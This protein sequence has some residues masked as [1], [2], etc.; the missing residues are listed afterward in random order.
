VT[1]CLLF[2]PGGFIGDR[3]RATLAATPDVEVLV[4][5]R[6][7][8]GGAGPRG[9]DLAVDL[10][11]A[12]VAAVARVIRAAAP[13]VVINC[14][15]AT[16]GDASAMVA[17]NVVA[18]ATLV[19]AVRAAAPDA[20][21][22]HLGSAAEYGRVTPGRPVTEAT[23]PDPVGAYGFT[24]LAG[25]ELVR[26]AGLDAV[27]LR[28]FNLIGPGSPPTGLP[29]RLVA[30][31]RRA[32]QTGDAVRVGSL[33]AHRD[34]VDIRDVAVAVVAAALAPGRLP[35]VLNVGS[36]VATPLRELADALR[37]ITGTDAAVHEVTAGSARSAD[38]P[39]QCADASAIGAALGWSAGITVHD[40]LRDLWHGSACLA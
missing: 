20:R 9:A 13:D 4:S 23:P 16:Y 24:K 39:W 36:G 25:T 32:A 34:F 14:A 8:I 29:G 31:F 3:V 30:E 18:V 2:G 35:A 27:V 37:A 33:E 21:L 40:S 1:R 15:G 12:G 6:P 11:V 5:A 19:E 10:A 26:A 17:G 7:A 28:I 22:V 38:V